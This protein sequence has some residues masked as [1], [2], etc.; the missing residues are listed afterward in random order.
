[1]S[2]LDRSL[3]HFG[4]YRRLL[5]FSDFD[6]RPLG[7]LGIDLEFTELSSSSD[8]SALRANQARLARERWQRGDTCLAAR[9]EG[10][11][12]GVCW[13]A[14]ETA[15]VDYLGAE[16]RLA[17]DAVYTYDSYVAAAFRGRRVA[18][19]LRLASIA[20]ARVRGFERTF[21]L[22]WPHN[23][24][25]M[26]RSRRMAWTEIGEIVRFGFGPRAQLSFRL[27]GEHHDI[28]GPI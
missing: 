10:N 4:I 5:A 2:W 9:F 21:S 25:S 18:D 20:W 12:V 14:V 11:L 7:S 8:Y 13:C 26:H 28:C 23:P 27:R 15:R 22:I 24:A 19:G 1:M 16:I 6:T 3:Q 17:E